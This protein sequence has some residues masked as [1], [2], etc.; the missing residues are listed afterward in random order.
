MPVYSNSVDTVDS[1][2]TQINQHC[3]PHVLLTYF[4]QLDS[5]HSARVEPE[6]KLAKYINHSWILLFPDRN[7]GERPLDLTTQG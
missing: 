7:S 1:V 2:D 4:E 3:S 5:Q 6:K